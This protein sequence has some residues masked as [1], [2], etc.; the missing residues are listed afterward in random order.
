MEQYEIPPGRYHQTLCY[1]LKHFT[2]EH[3]FIRLVGSKGGTVK[4]DGT[5][6]VDENVLRKKLKLKLC[7]TTTDLINAIK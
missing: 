6:K 4:K 2:A 7:K 3:I 1:A 5:V